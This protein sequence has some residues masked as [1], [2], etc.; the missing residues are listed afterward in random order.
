MEE[1]KHASV[2]YPVNNT[3]EKL[4]KDNI[5]KHKTLCGRYVRRKYIAADDSEVTCPLCFNLL[6]V[7]NGC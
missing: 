5:K 7:Y 3:A 4:I 1:Y 6:G 2:I